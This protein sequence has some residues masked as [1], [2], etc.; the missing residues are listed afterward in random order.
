MSFADDNP[1]YRID[2]EDQARNWVIELVETVKAARRDC[3]VM[4]PG[5]QA[6]TAA[7]QRK[8]YTAFLMKHGSALGTLM[9]LHR[10]GKLG[11]VAY[12]ELRQIAMDTLAATV[13]GVAGELPGLRG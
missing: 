3:N 2:T 9:A 11:D 10:C 12:N 5:D 8:A 1:G 7:H 13:V 4:Y 6:R